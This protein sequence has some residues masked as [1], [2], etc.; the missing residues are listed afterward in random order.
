ML[1]LFWDCTKALFLDWLVS[2]Q[3]NVG[4]TFVPSLAKSFMGFS[5][6]KFCK[7]IRFKSNFF[8]SQTFTVPVPVK[9]SSGFVWRKFSYLFSKKVCQEFV[10]K[11][12]NYNRFKWILQEHL[13]VSFGK[14]SNFSF[15]FCHYANRFLQTKP[16]C[17]HKGTKVTHSRVDYMRWRGCFRLLPKSNWTSESRS[18]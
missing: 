16:N 18:A 11:V 10:K 15:I 6:Y 4:G 17:R 12:E 1:F 13:N 5:L 8:K 7:R 2:N 3:T 14:I 9:V